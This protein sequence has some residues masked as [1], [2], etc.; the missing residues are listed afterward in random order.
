MA[1]ERV[2]SAAN[3]QLR[4][5]P[6]PKPP[7]LELHC[8]AQARDA[9]LTTP[10]LVARPHEC[11]LAL[12]PP[13]RHRRRCRDRQSVLQRRWPGCRVHAF[14][15]AAAQLASHNSEWHNGVQAASSHSIILKLLVL[16]IKIA[17]SW[18]SSKFITPNC[19]MFLM[20]FKTQHASLRQRPSCRR[21]V[22]ACS[23][24]PCTR[25]THTRTHMQTYIICIWKCMGAYTN[26]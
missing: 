1:H 22:V 9:S 26:L 3:D 14:G 17:G 6:C 15:S 11:S 25:P 8:P 23:L 7:A 21:R 12:T 24:V 18:R 20:E 13:H 5:R 16:V 19:W 10:L 2:T 4:S